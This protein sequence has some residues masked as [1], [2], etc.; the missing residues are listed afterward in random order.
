MTV[1]LENRDAHAALPVTAS[2]AEAL[3]GVRKEIDRID[4]ALLSLLTE[5]F[6]AVQEVR[7][8]KGEEAAGLPPLRPSRE[9]E[10]IR[11]L[12]SL[13]QAPL[14]VEVVI[15]VWREIMGTAT[16][17]QQTTRVHVPCSPAGEHGFR[18]GVKGAFGSLAPIVEH[19][20]ATSAVEML[21]QHPQ[22]L[23]AVPVRAEGWAGHLRGRKD[24]LAVVARLPFVGG[25]EASDSF[26]IGY[27][28]SAP[29]GD[30]ETLVAMLCDTGTTPAAANG[31]LRALWRDQASTNEG[32]WLWLGILGGWLDVDA[33]RQAFE[34]ETTGILAVE[35]LGRYATPI[36]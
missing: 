1:A 23:V 26:I 5:R 3:A 21:E 28:P 14:P 19:S 20:D 6:T 35:V 27:T 13:R 12:L 36:R 24:D 32:G 31:N 10:V 33:A 25:D 17:I 22:D 11:R 29:T 7:R 4:T 18:D 16:Q 30:D 34:P 9:A 15:A 2:D 8:V